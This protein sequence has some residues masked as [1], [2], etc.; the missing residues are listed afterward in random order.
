MD[1]LVS[2]N[3]SYVDGMTAADVLIFT[4][5]AGDKVGATKMDRP[6]DVEPSLL[7]GKV[8]VALTNNTNRGQGAARPRGRRGQPAQPPTS[9]GRSWSSPRT[10]ATTRRDDV[11]L[12][13][14]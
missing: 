7:T 1:Q 10:A 8:Y 6:E 14:A 3:R 2:G 4:R 5:L 11:H 13:A 12:V 9:T